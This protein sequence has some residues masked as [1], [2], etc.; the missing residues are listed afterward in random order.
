M[1]SIPMNQSPEEQFLH[2]CQDMER[3]QEEQA[4][5]MKELQGRVECLRLE[6][7]QLRVHI[8]KSRDLGKYERDSGCDAQLIARDKRRG[9]F[10]LTTSIPQRTMS[11]PQAAPHP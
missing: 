11:Y 5:Q 6:N 9:S 10:F 3:K 1:T 4:R 7:D 2:W 8:K